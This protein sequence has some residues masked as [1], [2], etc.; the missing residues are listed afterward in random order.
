M[1]QNHMSHISD[2]I[3]D[4]LCSTAE[5]CKCTGCFSHDKVGS[6]PINFEMT[7]GECNR[8]KGADLYSYKGKSPPCFLKALS[9][10]NIRI[11]EGLHHLFTEILKCKKP[12]DQSGS[13]F[14]LRKAVHFH[15]QIESVQ[16]LWTKPSF[17][18]VHGREELE[19]A[20]C[21]S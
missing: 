20:G 17:I 16:K 19:A 7:H 5:G 14:R 12:L 18:V 2:I 13:C 1:S 6:V 3:P 10:D 21:G 8:C 15:G 11:S 4:H 9:K